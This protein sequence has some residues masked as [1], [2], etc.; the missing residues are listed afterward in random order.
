MQSTDSHT[1]YEVERN[2]ILSEHPDYPKTI[3]HG[4]VK[5]KLKVTRAFVLVDYLVNT[6]QDGSKRIGLNFEE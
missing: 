6:G 3:V 2:Q 4:K 1:V 5:G